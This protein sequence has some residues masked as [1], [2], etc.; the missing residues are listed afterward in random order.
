MG[1]FKGIN[2]IF[3]EHFGFK[4]DNDGKVANEKVVYCLKCKKP[5][6]YCGSKSSLKYHLQ[7]KHSEEIKTSEIKSKFIFFLVL[8]CYRILFKS[9]C[10]S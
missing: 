6:S 8:K 3:Q 10:Y 9:R 7:T 1:D 2:G 5:F 4:L